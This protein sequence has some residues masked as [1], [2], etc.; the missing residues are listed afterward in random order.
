MKKNFIIYTFIIFILTSFS[1]FAERDSPSSST[2]N[3]KR[4]IKE[5]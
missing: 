4:P 5:K 1:I 3:Y 2:R